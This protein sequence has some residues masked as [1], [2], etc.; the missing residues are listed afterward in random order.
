MV[1]IPDGVKL[2][3][4]LNISRTEAGVITLTDINSNI[5][6]YVEYRAYK[7]GKDVTDDYVLIFDTFES[8]SDTYVPLR[9]DGRLITLTSASQTKIYDGEMLTNP[10]VMIT[11][12]SLIGGHTLEAVASGYII[13]PGFAENTLD[14]HNIRIVD[15]EGRDVTYNYTINIRNGILTVVEAEDD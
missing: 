2:E 11:Q 8:T 15:S 5:D 7:N 14:F 3:L 10:Q 4:H 9:V 1:E 12:G 6:R 13:T